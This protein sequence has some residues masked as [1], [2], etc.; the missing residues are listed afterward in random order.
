VMVTRQA[1]NVPYDTL[2]PSHRYDRAVWYMEH[3]RAAQGAKLPEYAVVL[4]AIGDADLAM[5]SKPA[6]SA[7]L[8]HN[9]RP[10]LN[11]PDRVDATFRSRLATTLVGIA[12][13]VAP[14]TVRLAGVDIAAKGLLGAVSAAKMTP[15]VLVRPVGLHGGAGLTLANDAAELAAIDVA[16]VG[17]VYVSDFVD[18][19]SADGFYRK[20]RVIYVDRKAF[21]YHLAISRNWMVHHR[22]SEMADDAARKA[23]ELSFLSDPAAA[24]GARA[25]A[26][27]E[28]IGRRL[29]LDYGGIDF[30]VL[31]D[32]QVLVFEANATMLTHLE[33]EDGPFA[34]K[35]PFVRPI[36]DAFQ[37]H[38]AAIV[39]GASD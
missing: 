16:G 39:D 5:A 22:S 38:L 13:V 6:V 14:R 18:Y 20:Y 35:N 2:L 15:P 33:D 9:T 34:A 1:G 19:R 27:V 37:A 4:N 36:I 28:A 3:A 25:M 30:S 31:P 10:V 7:F 12:D 11:H 21:P 26:A 32:G 29:D 24:I 8:G 23:E 17:D